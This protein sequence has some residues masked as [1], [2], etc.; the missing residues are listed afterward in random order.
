MRAAVV[1]AG[2]GGLAAATLLASRGVDVTVYELGGRPGGKIG[3]ASADGAEFDTG[4]TV[5]TLPGVADAILEEAGTRLEEEID[6]VETSPAFR[7]LYPGGET[8]DVHPD[9][10]ST[11]ADI[12][13]ELGPEAAD[14]FA[15][16]LDYARE[17]WEAA[18]P[19]FVFDEAP[20]LGTVLGMGLRSLGDL[21]AID[22]TRTMWSAICDQVRSRPL[23]HLLAR[24]ATYVGSHPARAPATLNCIAWVEL[25]EGHWGVS[26][27]MFRLVEALERAARRRG[28]AFHYETPVEAIRGGTEANLRVE[29]GEA[30]G[31]FDAVVCN[32]DVRHL[33]DDLWEGGGTTGVDG[34]QA[35]SMSGW[36]A[37]FRASRSI[38]GGRAPHTVLF[39]EDYLDEFEAIFER[40]EVPDR[41]TIYLCDQRRAHRRSGWQGASPV[42]AMVNAPPVE[43]ATERPSPGV[44]ALGRRV[45]ER[46]AEAGLLDRGDEIVWERTPGELARR[47]PGSRGAI[48]GAASNSRTAAFQRPANRVPNVEGLY[49]ASGSAHPGGGVPMALQSGRIAA[50]ALTDDFALESS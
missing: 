44:E 29:A 21:S 50:D 43:G 3:V 4:P 9:V 41:P 23:R 14:E 39:P 19:N 26:G 27:G 31:D 49:L 30:G 40:G 16:F 13:D 10:E 2:A 35:P 46:L 37:V 15:G 24:Y 6:L 17:V 1:G 45:G 7:Y 12:R 34:D 28:A 48:Y 20:T 8:L 5:L 22:P 42:F 32:A 47:H 11:L 33:V 18:A 38:T 36:T 25:G